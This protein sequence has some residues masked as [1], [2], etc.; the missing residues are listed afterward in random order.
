MIGHVSRFEPDH[1][2]AKQVLDQGLLGQ[3][4]MM[5]H[6]MTTSMP[7]WSEDGW[8]ADPALS[9]GPLVDLAV[10]SFDYLAWAAD[11]EAVR[12]HAV[13]RDTPA[14]PNTYALAT[15]RY[16]SG[17]MALVE[18][19]WA[20]P[21]S[22]GF[23]LKA[24]F[25]GTKGRLNWSYDQ[26]NGGAMFVAR[27]QTRWFD[28]LGNRGFRDELGAFAD[29]VR[30]GRASPVPAEAAYTALRTALGALESVQTGEII[31]LT[32]WGSR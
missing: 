20:H 7:G 8:L 19:S 26:I 14:G 27:G 16:A 11:S 31:D 28:P 9:G 5:S 3:V 4:Q 18:S 24:E 25:I 30:A 32:T 23:K 22:H 17:T 2:Q 29:A 13:G 1:R 6:S 21:V 10:H 12:V 15:V